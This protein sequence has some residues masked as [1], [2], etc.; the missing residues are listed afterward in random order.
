MGAGLHG[1][2]Q[3]HRAGQCG[4][5]ALLRDGE[6]V[7]QPHEAALLRVGVSRELEGVAGGDNAVEGGIHE[8]GADPVVGWFGG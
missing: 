7:G 6:A 2:V 3:D 5:Q 4:G 1:R 8:E